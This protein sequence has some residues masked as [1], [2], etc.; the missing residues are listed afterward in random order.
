MEFEGIAIYVFFI[1]PNLQQSDSITTFSAANF[2]IDGQIVG[3]F[4][5]S[6][7][8]STTEILYNQMV[9]NKTDL[10]NGMHQLVVSPALYDMSVFISFDYAIY[11]QVIDETVSTNLYS[12]SSTFSTTKS[13]AP[14]SGTVIGTSSPTGSDTQNSVS[15][16]SRH[17]TVAIIGATIGGIIIIGAATALFVWRR[18][19][20]QKINISVLTNYR[21]PWKKTPTRV[22]SPFQL[23]ASTDYNRHHTSSE[24]I[25][26]RSETIS[27]DFAAMQHDI[28]RN[29]FKQLG[30]SGITESRP[31][32][33]SV[34]KPP[35]R[36]NTT[37][38]DQAEGSAD[39]NDGIS[40]VREQVQVMQAQ[41]ELL[42][43]QQKNAAK[44][45]G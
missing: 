19:G 26:E 42:Q 3:N 27:N 9:F 22:Q 33:A 5:H 11:T 17:T 24:T 43:Q 6:P 32:H 38:N 4:S 21:V 15:S 35:L 36:V 10:P 28:F 23:V 20:K 7:D 29:Y 31:Q 8:L 34:H 14:V 1:L 30:R 2:T 12:S 40:R 13:D 45:T 39:Y 16:K 41:I 25:D 18:L 37:T 44:Y